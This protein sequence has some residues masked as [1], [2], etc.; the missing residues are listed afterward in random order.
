MKFEKKI[1]NNHKQNKLHFKK[2]GSSLKDYKIIK[3]EIEKYF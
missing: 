2:L 3:G 1:K